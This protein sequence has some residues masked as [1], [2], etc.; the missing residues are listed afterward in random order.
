MTL[1]PYRQL[2]K[3]AESSL[4]YWSEATLTEFIDDLCRRINE[5]NISRTEL[6]RRLGTSKAYVTKV[7]GGNANFT[8]STMVKLALAVEGALHV[9]IA[10]K[11]AITRW[12]DEY[13]NEEPTDVRLVEAV[14]DQ[15]SAGAAVSTHQLETKNAIV[16]CAW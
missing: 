5:K 12:I 11:T 3:K 2:I 16:N 1:E 9:H 10:D 6:S 7:L 8:L 15:S 4:D 14:A 13:T